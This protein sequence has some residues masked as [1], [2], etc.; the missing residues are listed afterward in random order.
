M[1][2]PPRGAAHSSPRFA[3]T[4]W[5][6]ILRAADPTDPDARPALADLCQAYWYPLYAF[7]RRRGASAEEAED[8]VQEFFTWLMES[9]TLQYA[10]PAR[11]RF[12]G[13]LVA[14]FRQFLAR[15]H[16]YHTAQ[17]RCPTPAIISINAT[18]GESRYAIEPADP[19]TPERM[20]EYAW[21][22][23]VLQRALD[24][25]RNEYAGGKV[26]KLAALEGLLTGQ[27]DTTAAEV[28]KVI[29][30]TEGAVRVAIHRMRKRYGELLRVE[31]AATIDEG[32]DVE[33]EL[34]CL[35]AALR[36]DAPM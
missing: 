34:R 33:A 22:V 27:A 11:G 36:P 18:D 7:H 2:V 15:R 6:R 5:S 10:D 19:A 23:A 30:M 35:L 4:A 1:S 20:F 25:L 3:T 26:E 31:V 9:K 8:A 21:A 12:R 28:G 32:E 24:Q 14:A 29:G 16:E 13:F 17:K